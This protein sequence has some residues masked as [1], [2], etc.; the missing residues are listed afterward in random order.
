MIIITFMLYTCYIDESKKFTEEVSVGPEVVLFQIGIKVVDEQF[1]FQFLVC[2]RL[3]S[4]IKI[5]SQ[6][7]NLPGFPVFPEPPW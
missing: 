7:Q 3:D 2:V 1:L 4:N 5:H 6:G